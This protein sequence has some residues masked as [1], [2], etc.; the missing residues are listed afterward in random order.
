M[1]EL[2]DDLIALRREKK[3]HIIT[4]QTEHKCVLDSCRSLEQE[5]FRVTFLPVLP[6]GLVDLNVLASSITPETSLV[7]IMGVNNEIGVLQPMKEIG[8]LC[9]SRKVFFHTDAAQVR[10]CVRA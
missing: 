6:S 9:R 7:S 2:H 8:A 5:G 3:R 1:N 4:T 10:A